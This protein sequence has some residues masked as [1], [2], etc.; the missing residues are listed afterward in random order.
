M[1]PCTSEWADFFLTHQTSNIKN[2]MK[3]KQS[4][5]PLSFDVYFLFLTGSKTFLYHF[6]V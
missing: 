5:G 1:Y 4:N 2:Y 3:W 6:I